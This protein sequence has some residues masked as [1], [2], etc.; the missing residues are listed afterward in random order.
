MLLALGEAGA[1]LVTRD[2]RTA[3][4]FDVPTYRIVTHDSGGHALLLA[5]RGG[6]WAVA[7]VALLQRKVEPLTHLPLD[8]FAEDTDGTLWVVCERGAVS[9]LDLSSPRLAALW[10]AHV[11][12]VLALA[13][14][15]VSLSLLL[16]HG[17]HLERWS[18]ELPAFTLRV[19]QLLALPRAERFSLTTAGNLTAVDAAGFV[20]VQGLAGQ[21]ATRSVSGVWAGYPASCASAG[22]WTSIVTYRGATCLWQLADL[23]SATVRWRAELQHEPAHARVRMRPDVA[24]WADSEGRVLAVDLGT[25]R[26][27]RDLRVR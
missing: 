27:L 25:G 16:G 13:R 19:R 14:N 15:T 9:V 26:L 24:T 12:Q 7:R 21:S 17:E 1:R 23:P 8:S 4:H 5:P 18:Y 6:A 10:R 11:P 22:D 20:H 2:G 3:A